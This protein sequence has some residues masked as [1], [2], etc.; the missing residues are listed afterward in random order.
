M[1][2]NYS[3]ISHISLLDSGVSTQ[4]LNFSKQSIPNN[5]V[6]ALWSTINENL[7]TDFQ[8]WEIEPYVGQTF[9]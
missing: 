3:P 9:S 1:Q 6:D 4:K 5:G 2:T 8:I 7:H